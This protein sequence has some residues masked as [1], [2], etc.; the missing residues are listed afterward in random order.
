MKKYTLLLCYSLFCF[1]ATAQVVLLE[2][3]LECPGEYH[4]VW[5]DEFDGNQIDRSL[6]QTTSTNPAPL[7]RLPILGTPDGCTDV[8]F[9]C[10]YSGREYASD[11]NVVVQNGTLR[12]IT[13]EETNT[14]TGIVDAP[15]GEILDT[16][17]ECFVGGDPFS[18]TTD[19]TTGTVTSLAGFNYGCFEMRGKIPA[20]SQLWPSY[21][22]WGTDE[23]DVFEFFGDPSRQSTNI[24]HD[25]NMDSETFELADYSGGFHVYKVEWTPFD[26]TWYLDGDVIRKEYKFYN[27][28]GQGV[29]C[30]DNVPFGSYFRNPAFPEGV[31]DSG[32]PRWMKIYIGTGIYCVPDL[33]ELPATFELDY[34][35]VYQRL[36]EEEVENRNLCHLELEGPESVCGLNTYVYHLK[37]IDPDFTP[38]WSTSNH[39][40]IIDQ[41][42]TK[43]TVK[44][45]PGAS[46]AGWI[47]VN[48][49][50]QR[51]Y[52]PTSMVRVD[53]E[54]ILAGLENEN[55]NQQT[56]FCWK[57]DVFYNGPAGFD[58]PYILFS[59]DIWLYQVNAGGQ[60]DK[61][62]TSGGIGS[63]PTPLNL[64]QLFEN[65]PDG[66]SITFEAGASY[67]ILIFTSHVLCGEGDFFRLSFNYVDPAIRIQNTAG[68]EKE[69]YCLDE[70]IILDGDLSDSEA[71][72][73][74]EVRERPHGEP[75][76]NTLVRD[77]TNE[78]ELPLVLNDWMQNHSL[79]FEA[80]SEYQ[81][82]LLIQN[83]CASDIELIQSFKITGLLTSSFRFEDAQGNVP[84][85]FC[86][87]EDV[88]INGNASNYEDRYWLEVGR[89]PIGSDIFTGLAFGGVEGEIETIN[90]SEWMTSN[91][92][93]L[94]GDFVYQVKL[95]VQ[96]DCE[97]WVET[98]KRFIMRECC[99][100]PTSLFCV[101]IGGQTFLSWND[102]S[103]TSTYMLF[104]DPTTGTCCGNEDFSSPAG[105]LVTGNLFNIKG[106]RAE[107]FEW[108]VQSICGDLMSGVSTPHCMNSSTSCLPQFSGPNA[109]STQLQL[110]KKQ[111]VISIAVSPN[112]SRGPIKI[113][114]AQEETGLLQI[115]IININGQQ[116]KR[117]DEV[118]ADEGIY[119]QKWTRTPE[120]ASG[121]YFLRVH[122][123]QGTFYKKF[124][125]QD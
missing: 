61:L 34:M 47:E 24:H 116:I 37:N 75:D 85:E 120:V 69:A 70:Q 2:G 107:C 104:I 125:I 122:T 86:S 103:S 123:S 117:F 90:F 12:L 8:E 96:N 32:L 50:Q 84:E 94:T 64:T 16:P 76:F 46:G 67:E 60:W 55:G 35:R 71:E 95:A 22:L 80:G 119:E 115:E 89:A 99:E 53:V 73:C 6:W 105:I 58:S 100:A 28:I 78:F 38:V 30:G 19:F 27:A 14:Y 54:V 49:A 98:T 45:N 40:T 39:F 74:L 29:G 118:M 83:S 109:P 25:G 77:C 112:P 113:E 91:G 121:I 31:S 72:Y 51:S 82:V 88:F 52:C 10:S 66:G 17:A 59:Y 41:D 18:V 93:P 7:D 48:G 21:W 102:V 3:E 108:R 26:M 20:A 5:H 97:P 68:I 15:V 33:A 124:I 1:F 57:Q 111:E 106:I 43:A 114:V 42:E 87:S 92:V 79:M 23:I 63:I 110:Q 65:N 9:D 4:L 13:K 56:A 11:A 101:E 36:S 44:V 62:A 81:V